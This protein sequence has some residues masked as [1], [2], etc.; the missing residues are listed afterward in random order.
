M[1]NFKFQLMATQA[2]HNKYGFCPA[3][4]QVKLLESSEDGSYIRFLVDGHEYSC[5]NGEITNIEDREKRV[6]DITYYLEICRE[7]DRDLEELKA[8]H[9]KQE[10][11]FVTKELMLTEAY[12]AKRREIED[13]ENRLRLLQTL[14]DDRRVE[15]E[16]LEAKLKEIRNKK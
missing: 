16:K 4:E 15:I 5:D 2:L 14:A 9:E 12:N 6:R 3:T 11:Q 10:Q 1:N 13:W 7:K 8:A